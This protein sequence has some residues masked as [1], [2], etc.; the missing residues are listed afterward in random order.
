M[1][2]YDLEQSDQSD[3]LFL[4]QSDCKFHNASSS[5]QDQTI[6][7]DNSVLVNSSQVLQRMG[8]VKRSIYRWC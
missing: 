5:L 1:L 8:K 2:G 4:N 3:W 6:V 7:E